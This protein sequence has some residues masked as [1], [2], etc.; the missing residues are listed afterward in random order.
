M[1][2]LLGKKNSPDIQYRINLG[3]N[4]E[5]QHQELL[6]MDIKYILSQ[7]LIPACYKLSDSLGSEPEAPLRFVEIQGGLVQLG[8]DGTTNGFQFDNETPRFKFFLADFSLASRPVTNREFLAFIEDGGYEAPLL[9]KSDGWDYLNAHNDRSP[10]YW[11]KRDGKWYE[12]TLCGDFPLNLDL[13]VS[14][15][16]YYEA[17]A[18]AAWSGARLPTEMEF[19]H[20][21]NSFR[22]PEI[23]AEAGGFLESGLLHQSLRPDS[24]SPFLSL[25]GNLWEWS[26][27]SYQ[28]YPNYHKPD[29]AFGEYNQ[30]FMVNQIV[31]RGGC[32]ATPR[33]HFRNTY[34]NYFYPYQK[35]AFTGLRLAKDLL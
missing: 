17:D 18:F 27:S 33:S 25:T 23:A 5:Q 10:L 34:R 21:Y 3:L 1:E 31:L 35:W 2:K 4:H 24:S 9:W 11:E 19:E 7:G 32:F 20:T 29:G 12:F 6:L 28:P 30:K 8:R 16:N 22:S 15:L 13:P 26:A 14:H